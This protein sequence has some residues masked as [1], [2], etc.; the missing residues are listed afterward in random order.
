V[1]AGRWWAGRERPRDVLQR[2]AL[3][4]HREEDGDEARADHERGAE[5]VAIVDVRPALRRDERAEQGRERI[6]NPV[7]TE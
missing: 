6:A 4:V 1:S 5:Q 2:A 7:P 3:R